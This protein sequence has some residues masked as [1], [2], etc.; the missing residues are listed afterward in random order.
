MTAALGFEKEIGRARRAGHLLA[1]LGVE[2]R[3]VLRK[4]AEY[5]IIDVIIKGADRAGALVGHGD[6]GRFSERHVPVAVPG[7]ALR[8]AVDRQGAEAAVEAVADA[9][10][11][12]DR[13]FDGG[14][15]F[16]VPVHP[17]DELAAV[18]WLG[19]DGHPD[20]VDGA[21]A[22]D[23]GQDG[24]GPGLYGYGVP[25]SAAAVIRR[26][27]PA[28]VVLKPAQVAEEILGDKSG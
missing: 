9:E 6:A 8:R 5:S 16:A 14:R 4:F 2:V 23:L 26:N 13:R 25:V 28:L 22:L 7:P 3:S 11:V 18:K 1:I 17:E 12:A 20:V 10:K 19:G 15:R 21:R 27:T 24:R